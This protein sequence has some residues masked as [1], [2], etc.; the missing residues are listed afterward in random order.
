VD[1]EIL[2]WVDWALNWSLI[3]LLVI[4]V[5][6]IWKFAEEKQMTRLSFTVVISTYFLAISY[7]ELYAITY[8]SIPIPF[9]GDYLMSKSGLGPFALLIIFAVGMRL[10]GKKIMLVA[11]DKWSASRLP[12]QIG[13][14]IVAVIVMMFG[15]FCAFSGGAYAYIRT[16]LSP[17]TGVV[18]SVKDG[19]STIL[20]MLY[21]EGIERTTRGNNK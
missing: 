3:F 5:V 9:I 21:K 16:E 20:K 15:L 10:L 2:T 18:E 19:A 4:G 6:A 8:K 12:G 1:T 17:A 13:P 14:F 11:A 7:G